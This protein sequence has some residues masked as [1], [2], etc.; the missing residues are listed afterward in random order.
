[1]NFEE[2]ADHV[3]N[4]TLSIY[5]SATESNVDKFLD[6]YCFLSPK[7]YVLVMR[8]VLKKLEDK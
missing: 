5:G 4:E 7:E 1:M 2:F 8:E 3:I 6:N